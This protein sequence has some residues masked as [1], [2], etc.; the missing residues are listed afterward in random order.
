MLLAFV[1][2][3][4][5]CLLRLVPWAAWPFVTHPSAQLTPSKL[6][7]LN[8]RPIRVP[9]TPTGPMNCNRL[10]LAPIHAPHPTRLR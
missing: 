6:L 4:Q 5:A 7:R 3:M 9:V 10:T 2:W 8:L 1:M